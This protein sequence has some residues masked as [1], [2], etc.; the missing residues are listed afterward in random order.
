MT[1]WG[2]DYYDGPQGHA[3]NKK[4]WNAAR[5]NSAEETFGYISSQNATSRSFKVA[6]NTCL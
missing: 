3:A 2:T 1:K 5:T 6:Q 4:N